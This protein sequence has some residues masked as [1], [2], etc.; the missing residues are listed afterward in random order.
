MTARMI[1]SAFVYGALVV[2]CA[3]LT[4][5][6]GLAGGDETEAGPSADGQVGSADADVVD[7]DAN[8]VDADAD[9]V[10]ADADVVDTDGD[11]LR[12][13]GDGA[14]SC[15]AACVPEAPGGWFG[16]VLLYEG[17]AQ[18]EPPP[19]TGGA[20]VYE[21]KADPVAP[22]ASCARC[23]CTPPTGMTCQ[24]DIDVFPAYNCTG[25]PKCGHVS[26]VPGN[27][28][29][30]TPVP[31]SCSALSSQITLPHAVGGSCS[32]SGGALVDAAAPSWGRKARVCPATHSSGTCRS[33]E[34]CVVR[35]SPPFFSSRCI[36]HIGV[37]VACPDG[38][39]YSQ[40]YVY[41]DG[42]T[43]TR[44]CAPCQCGA[45][46]AGCTVGTLSTTECTFYGAH[47]VPSCVNAA[48][49]SAYA[50][51]S[52]SASGRCPVSGGAPMGG[53]EA[54]NPTTICCTP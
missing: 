6:D 18:S 43:D 47:A 27:G 44:S 38:G 19:C 15:T 40:R 14:I 28:G 20:V 1:A 54:A 7:A 25:A 13:G 17:T 5:L 3:L 42:V 12:D 16:P 51:G 22:P 37:D 31:S 21:G 48:I 39:P 26:L 45:P 36:A 41:Y 30:C 35:P 33:N 8:V 24:V 11:V 32:P 2:G 52:G 49:T 29:A 9:V 53:I 4:D 10:D 34:V 46:D 50:T 23:D